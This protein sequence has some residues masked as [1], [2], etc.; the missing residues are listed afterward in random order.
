MNNA[1]TIKL[2]KN[3]T[4]NSFVLR[5]VRYLSLFV[6]IFSTQ[7][8]AFSQFTDAQKIVLHSKLEKKLAEYKQYAGFTPNFQISEATDPAYEQKFKTLFVNNAIVFNDLETDSSKY[9]NLPVSEYST[10]LKTN[11]KIGIAVKD[12]KFNYF[13][14]RPNSEASSQAEVPNILRANITKNW[15]GYIEDTVYIDKSFT[16]NLNFQLSKTNEILLIT[17]VEH[18]FPNQ[19]IEKKPNPN[20]KQID[21]LSAKAT[22]LQAK[23]DNLQNQLTETNSQIEILEIK[24][25]DEKSRKSEYEHTLKPQK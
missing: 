12:V 11:Y 9:T 1:K 5:S 15:Y 16:L 3:N 4:N 8:V 14:I 7:F 21:K 10:F 23:I 19:K 13:T 18:V 17:N 20:Q 25:E 6:L 24:P 2:K 22:K